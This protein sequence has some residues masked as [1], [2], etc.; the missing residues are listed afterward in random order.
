MTKNRWR[1]I[2][3]LLCCVIM[4]VAAAP[5]LYGTDGEGLDKPPVDVPPQLDGPRLVRVYFGEDR[6]LYSGVLKSFDVLETDYEHGYHVVQVDQRDR[7]RLLQA[8]VRLETETARTLE[9]YFQTRSSAEV[10]VA[11]ISGYP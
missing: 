8:G 10:Q 3:T 4:L 1:W 6:A 11:T 9:G 2:G 7:N 5:P